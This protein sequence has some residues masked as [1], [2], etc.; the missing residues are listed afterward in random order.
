MSILLC[1]KIS[2][3]CQNYI[4]NGPKTNE[5]ICKDGK[6]YFAGTKVCHIFTDNKLI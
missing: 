2:R 4:D 3:K 6:F 5:I 1:S